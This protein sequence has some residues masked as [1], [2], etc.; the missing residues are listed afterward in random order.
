MKIA[1]GNDHRG[2]ELKKSIMRHFKDQVFV[3]VGTPS[4]ESTDYVDYAEKVCEQILSGNCQYGILICGSGI[5][6]SIVANRF[7]GIRAAM[8]W[9]T[10]I[11]EFCRKHNDANVLCLASDCVDDPKTQEIIKIFLNTKFEGGRHKQRLEKI[12]HLEKKLGFHL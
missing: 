11:A 9:N 3:D 6:M 4:H 8:V 2:V 7:A 5:G 1:I 10:H 12:R